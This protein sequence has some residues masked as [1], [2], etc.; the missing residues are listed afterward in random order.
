MMDVSE[1]DLTNPSFPSVLGANDVLLGRGSGANRW[2]GN[3]RFRALVLQI[4]KEYMA[5]SCLVKEDQYMSFSSLDPFVKKQI[6][7]QVLTSIQEI[8]GRFLYK[9][10]KEEYYK[11][12]KTFE[13]AI[14]HE[15]VETEGSATATYVYVEATPQKAME[16]IKQTLRFLTDQKHA[17]LLRKEE[18][19]SIASPVAPTP[20]RLKNT[21]SEPSTIIQDRKVINGSSLSCARLMQLL[22]LHR[23]AILSHRNVLRPLVFNSLTALAPVPVFRGTESQPIMPI[24]PN[25]LSTQRSSLQS[26]AEVFHELEALRQSQAKREIL[27]L[28]AA[29]K[30][31]Y[32]H[33]W[34]I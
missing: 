31:K 26:T 14:V 34:N 23:S 29:Q 10:R 24:L 13:S 20:L 2:G 33:Q 1:C 12:T 15:G 16:K 21:A 25:L 7:E 22:A 28:L 17:R 11:H 30:L 27:L 8:N 9:L 5:A 6:A 4:F 19:S 18:A 32:S 3:I